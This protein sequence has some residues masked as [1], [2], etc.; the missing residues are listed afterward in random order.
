MP[1]TTNTTTHN[2]I[3]PRD[4]LAQADDD[5][6]LVKIT[7]ETHGLLG[8][9]PTTFDQEPTADRIAAGHTVPAIGL[10]ATPVKARHEHLRTH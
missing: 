6:Y 8:Y 9:L 3:S 7:H 1:P 10:T 2:T 4:V 5:D